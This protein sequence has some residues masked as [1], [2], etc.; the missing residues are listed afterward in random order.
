MVGGEVRK[1]Q[2]LTKQEIE[3]IMFNVIKESMLTLAPS[4][5]DYAKAIY[6]AQE[7]KINKNEY[8]FF[9]KKN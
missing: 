7:R 8:L 6:E 4:I 5:K 1:D 3:Q 9:K 2:L